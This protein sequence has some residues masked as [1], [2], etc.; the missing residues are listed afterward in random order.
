LKAHFSGLFGDGSPNIISKNI[1]KIRTDIAI[2]TLN[3]LVTHQIS[4]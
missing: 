3:T 2:T 4:R 1:A